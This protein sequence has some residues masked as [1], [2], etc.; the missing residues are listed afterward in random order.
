MYFKTA[1][2]YLIR[3]RKHALLNISGLA[4]A[5][6][7][8]IVIF[9]VIQFEFSYDKHLSNYKSIY[10]VVAKDK[11]A[12]GEHYSIAMP[13]PAI[14][15]LRKDFSQYSFGQ[16]MHEY[17]VQVSAKDTDGTINEK[18]F[19][20][21]NGVFYGEPELMKIF[22]IKFLVGNADV[23]KDVSSAA[24]S[25]SMAE[26][27]FGK[28][29]DAIGRRLNIDN[30]EYDFQVA[31]V[32][33][34]APENSD[35]RFDIV[36]SYAGFVSRIWVIGIWKNGIIITVTTRYI[37]YY[38]PIQTLLL[39]ITNLLSLKKN[40][41]PAIKILHVQISCNRLPIYILIIALK[42]METI[43]LVN[44]PY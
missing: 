23:L 28:W 2:S 13:F 36:A 42:T 5:L 34:D 19:F 12:D 8:C 33:E 14:K 16:L 17:D 4:T 15:F 11:D 37:C 26:K 10:Q 7:A 41:I 31:A 21:A 35:F 22:E 6:A 20:E 18:K 29:Q 24:I 30:S 25:K 44:L 38:L 40:T 3:N 1:L 9:L 27:Y 39:L 32:F 43:R